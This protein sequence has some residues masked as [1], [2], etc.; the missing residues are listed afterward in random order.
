MNWF[1]IIF[2]IM[3]QE[4]ISLNAMVFG[5]YH[6]HFHVGL[7]NI[8]F[9]LATILDIFV[10]FFLGKYIHRKIKHGKIIA[11]VEKWSTRFHKHAGKSGRK[12]AFI[13]LGS[14]GFPYVNGFLAS[15]VCM[16]FLEALIFIF[17]GNMLWYGT[18]WLI[19]LGTVSTVPNPWIAIC[20]IIGVTLLIHTIVKR[21][22]TRKV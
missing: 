11:F 21:L 4:V 10:G 18:I 16:P 1:F 8:L 17:I 13:L 19:T 7:I 14:F 3:G 9:M 6:L 5:V 2:A 20:I 22:R 15:W 12:V